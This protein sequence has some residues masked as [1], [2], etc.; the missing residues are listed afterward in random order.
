MAARTKTWLVTFNALKT[1]S[2]L[3]SRKH[4]QA[5][6]PSVYMHDQP[7]KEVDF[8]QH[9][10]LFS[11]DCSWNKQIEYIFR[12]KHWARVNI[13]NTFKFD[14]YRKSLDIIYILLLFVLC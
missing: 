6:R 3:I 10:G 1:E 13:M 12:K 7:V 2:L 11:K 4:N 5:L 8:H 9:L 14:L